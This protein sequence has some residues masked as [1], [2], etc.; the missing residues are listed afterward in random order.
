M[1]LV[2]KSHHLIAAWLCSRNKET[3]CSHSELLYV[4]DDQCPYNHRTVSPFA[5]SKILL[6]C[7]IAELGRKLWK[8]PSPAQGQKEPM[9]SVQ[10]D[11]Q[12]LQG[13][14]LHNLSLGN[15]YQCFATLTGKKYRTVFPL[16]ACK[17]S[18]APSSLFPVIMYLYIS[19]RSLRQSGPGWILAALQPIPTKRCF[20]P[21]II[22]M[23][24]YRTC[25]GHTADTWFLVFFVGWLVFFFKS[26]GLPESKPKENN[27][28]DL[29]G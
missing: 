12:Y 14:R 16:S 23:A 3:V 7:K 4:W 9:A 8:S 19:I 17:K 28:A 24:L 1:S 18:L 26:P 2:S 13:W 29:K 21:F 5:A 20:N 22:I 25:S 11:F 6:K 15:L 10:S 27:S